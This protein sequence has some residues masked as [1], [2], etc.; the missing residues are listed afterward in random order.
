LTDF[1]RSL[2]CKKN[3]FRMNRQLLFIILFLSPAFLLGT[4]I[5]VSNLNNDGAGSLREAISQASDGDTIDMRALQGVILLDSQLV[6]N[7]HLSIWGPGPA[8]LAID[9]QDLHRIVW[10]EKRKQVSIRAIT[11][12]HG[13]GYL[14]STDVFASGG[15]I[16]NYGDLTLSA[17][18][19]RNCTA[20]FGGAIHNYGYGLDN[21]SSSLVLIG[22]SFLYNSATSPLPNFQGSP[23]NGGVVLSDGRENGFARVR[24]ENCHFEGNYAENDGGAFSIRVDRGDTAIALS[25]I[26]CTLTNNEAGV[27]GGAW[28]Q[29]EG[30][31]F[32]QNTILAENRGKPDNPNLHGALYTYGGVIIDR[33]LPNGNITYRNRQGRDLMNVAPQLGPLSIQANGLYARTPLCSSPAIGAGDGAT[34]GTPDQRGISRPAMPTAGTCEPGDG[35]KRVTTLADNGYGSLRY[36]SVHSCPGDTLDM[37]NLK[38]GI[39]L[40]SSLT[41]THDQVWLGNPR[42]PL[43]LKGSGSHRIL[44]IENNVSLF[45]DFMSFTNGRE[46]SYGGGA[47]RNF[48]K[49]ELWAVSLYGNE[50][51]S[52]GAIGN[53]GQGD[54]AASAYLINCT[55]AKNKAT[56]LDGGAIENV[57]FSSEAS[58]RLEH[59]TI[60][61]NEAQRR[62]GGLFNLGTAAHADISLS[63]FTENTAAEGASMYGPGSSSR[64]HNLFA[65][66]TATQGA[67]A[68]GMGSIVNANAALYPFATTYGGPTA[69]YALQGNSPAI[70]A[71]ISIPLLPVDQRGF[72]RLFGSLTDIG[73]YEY[74][75]LTSNEQMSGGSVVCYPNPGRGVF[76][77]S[78]DEMQHFQRMRVLDMQGRIILEKKLNSAAREQSFDISKQAS[79]LYNLI[80]ISESRKNELIRF[81]KH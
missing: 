69:C 43:I 79:G 64:G 20:G 66:T 7:N 81:V 77:V 18:V 25:L 75:P 27:L 30:R 49:L 59:C 8:N 38:G 67:P 35:D 13:N 50:A 73:A 36:A 42:D 52:G 3:I 41:V 4:V 33:L 34:A 71:G 62:G 68:M 1:L 55:L 24:A 39:S 37:R 56:T 26:H 29:F 23:K 11:F 32:I 80:L 6:I 51:P 21:D 22:C 57:P 76:Y 17:C 58:L 31:N 5:P 19:V 65:D 70:D 48:G 16:R 53:Y 44:T 78:S 28:A 14:D 47:I 9:G 45:A 72:I 54:S 40:D 10:I 63:I 46:S 61:E 15:A 74:N 60:A 2:A 12:Q